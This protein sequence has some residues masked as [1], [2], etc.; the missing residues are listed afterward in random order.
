MSDFVHEAE[1]R[2]AEARTRQSAS[3][4]VLFQAIPSWPELPELLTPSQQSA[5]LDAVRFEDELGQAADTLLQVRKD[6]QA[7]GAAGLQ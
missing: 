5:I 1:H 2:Y 3:R 7:P 4:T 6:A